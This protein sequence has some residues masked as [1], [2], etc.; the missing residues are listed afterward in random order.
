MFLFF[1]LSVDL[2][3]VRVVDYSGF[4]EENLEK[5]WAPGMQEYQ[6]GGE[7]LRLIHQDRIVLPKIPVML[8]DPFIP[9]TP[10]VRSISKRSMEIYY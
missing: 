6:I 7:V 10:S 3:W 2:R 9:A 4:M 5:Y 8:P 1:D